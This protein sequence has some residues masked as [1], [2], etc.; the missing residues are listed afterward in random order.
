MAET[1]PVAAP[2]TA[3]GEWSALPEGNVVLKCSH[4]HAV[5]Q[6][7]SISTIFF[8]PYFSLLPPPQFSSFR[9]FLVLPPPLCDTRAAAAAER[10]VAH[11]GDHG[12]NPRCPQVRLRIRS[13][14]SNTNRCPSLTHSATSLQHNNCNT[15][16]MYGVNDW[17]IVH[18]TVR[19]CAAHPPFIGRD[20]SW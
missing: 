12:A 20:P 6:H 3:T 7:P 16:F 8:H 19:A 14:H 15:V 4:L 13:Q 17:G 18:K 10:W 5:C 2:P 11:A 1:A 9:S